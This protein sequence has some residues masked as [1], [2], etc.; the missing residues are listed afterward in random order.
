MSKKVTSNNDPFTVKPVL[1]IRL[2]FTLNSIAQEMSF[3]QIN[4]AIKMAVQL[5]KVGASDM[6]VQKFSDGTWNTDTQAMEKIQHQLKGA[7]NHEAVIALSTMSELTNVITKE[8]SKKTG[9]SEDT[10]TLW[11]EQ[12]F[13]CCK[14]LNVDGGIL[15]EAYN[16]VLVPSSDDVSDN[17]ELE[18]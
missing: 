8:A 6:N 16:A 2:T 12:F 18:V 17:V 7:G 15:Q 1:P 11:V 13:T 5:G 9:A 3:N 10:I 4:A 14:A